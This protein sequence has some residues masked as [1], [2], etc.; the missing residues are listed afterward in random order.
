MITGIKDLDIDILVTLEDR[1]LINIFQTNKYL[2]SLGHNEHLW[3]KKVMCKYGNNE[4]FSEHKIKNWKE[5]YIN[6][7][8]ELEKYK[9]VSLPILLARLD[10]YVTEP[11]PSN[12]YIYFLKISCEKMVFHFPL[13]RYILYSIPFTIDSPTPYRIL[14]KVQKLANSS[15]TIEHYEKLSDL[16]DSIIENFSRDDIIE[17]KVKYYSIVGKHFSGFY[18][19]DKQYVALL[20][21]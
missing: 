7:F 2:Y 8:L 6:I 11:I 1:D 19:S 9:S 13:D 16:G 21:F 3:R 4:Y 5:L 10:W 20:E 14:K 15:V 17:E 18:N 12:L